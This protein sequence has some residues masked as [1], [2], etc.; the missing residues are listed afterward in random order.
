[1]TESQ[2][3]QRFPYFSTCPQPMVADILSNMQRHHFEKNRNVFLESDP[4]SVIAFLLSGKIRVYMLG[5]DGREITLYDVREGE[6]CILN[7]ACIL[8]NS[9][10]PARATVTQDGDGLIM[11]AKVFRDIV[12]R[13]AEMRSFV[14]SGLGERLISMMKL[15]EEVAFRR[16]DERLRRYVDEKAENGILRT[17]HQKIAN[18]L[19]SSREMVSRLLE[20]LERKGVLSL[21]RN[22]IQILQ[23]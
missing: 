5:N 7:V 17:T 18:E 11:P 15:V 19:G 3:L 1:M 21:S 13:Y 8:S 12:D 4:C 22:Q 2:F 23:P 6:T 16:L 14:Y 9:L 10:Y 20:D